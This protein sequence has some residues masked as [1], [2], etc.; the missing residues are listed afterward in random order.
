MWGQYLYILFYLYRP[1]LDGSVEVIAR[2]EL[3]INELA[4]FNRLI[5][6]P[7]L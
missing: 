5:C 6:S 2:I 7:M 4:I 3:R 1:H